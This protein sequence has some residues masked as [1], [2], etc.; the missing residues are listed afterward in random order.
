MKMFIKP[1][2]LAF[3]IGLI[4]TLGVGYSYIYNKIHT[5]T[6]DD[7]KDHTGKYLFNPDHKAFHKYEWTDF[8]KVYPTKLAYDSEWFKLPPDKYIP[9]EQPIPKQIRKIDD[10]IHHFS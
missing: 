7:I 8:K 6:P 3:A 5:N 4:I 10:I 9:K 2:K 1:K